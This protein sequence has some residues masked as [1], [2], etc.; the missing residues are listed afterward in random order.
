[1]AEREGRDKQQQ[2]GREPSREQNVPG[3]QGTGAGDGRTTQQTPSRGPDQGSRREE[4]E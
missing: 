4:L 3:R 2:P 1:M